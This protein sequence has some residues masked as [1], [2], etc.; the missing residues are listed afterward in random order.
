MRFSDSCYQPNRPGI[1][2]ALTKKNNKT[3]R[4]RQLPEAIPAFT[5]HKDTSNKLLL[6]IAMVV[7][8]R[9]QVE[10]GP[11]VGNILYV[12]PALPDSLI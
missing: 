10:G 4:L 9:K 1:T 12:G 6:V 3:Q 8:Q 11:L 7:S 2:A 5:A